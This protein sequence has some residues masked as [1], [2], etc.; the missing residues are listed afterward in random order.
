MLSS[1]Q[2]LAVLAVAWSRVEATPIEQVV[3]EQVAAK[4]KAAFTLDQVPVYRSKPLTFAE[5]RA[6]TYWKYGLDLPVALEAALKYA[7][8]EESEETDN[9]PPVGKGTS[10]VPVKAAKGEAE[11]L[12]TVQVGKHNLSLDPDTGSAD[13]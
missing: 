3:G 7:Q 5:V 10:T 4:G 8:T 2:T 12:I 1:L 9:A 13:L 6:R 11:F